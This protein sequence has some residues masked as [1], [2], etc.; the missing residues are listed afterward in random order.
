MIDTKLQQLE[1]VTGPVSRETY[2]AL[3]QFET[4]FLKWAPRINLTS[5][6]QLPKLWDRHIL[7][8]AQLLRLAPEAKRW[9]DFGSGGGFPGA[10]LAVLMRDRPDSRVRLVESNR[11]KAAFLQSVLLGTGNV[12]I[13][14]C[15]IEDAVGAIGETDI[16]T[17]RALAPL[18]RLLHLSELW[19]TT[20]SRALFMKGREFGAEVEESRDRWD[21]DLIEHQSRTNPDGVVLEISRLRPKRP[22][23][24]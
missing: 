7:D 21:F 4:T 19:L 8:S 13:L 17:A 14:P 10:V 3:L 12:E 16:I 11:K 15:R 2:D 22:S 23:G 5:A 18:P 9:A 6:S 1:A 20:G 24:H